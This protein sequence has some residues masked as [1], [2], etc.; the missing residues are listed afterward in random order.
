MADQTTV[1]KEKGKS[2]PMP[3]LL[4]ITFVAAIGVSVVLMTV[5]FKGMMP[6]GNRPA[7]AEA[8]EESET[9]F[10]SVIV[11]Y[12]LPTFR[13]NLSGGGYL[14]ATVVLELADNSVP[15]PEPKPVEGE[16]KPEAEAKKPEGGGHGG[17][18]GEAQAKPAETP[19]AK[20][21]A[22]SPFV[23]Y[24][25]DYRA[26]FQDIVLTI[27]RSQTK[28]DVL[29]EDGTQAVKNEIKDSINRELNP[30]MGLVKGVFFEEFVTD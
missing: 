23:K 26:K 10:E 15:P 28:E 19:A 25:D 17:G 18:G 30:Q 4:G 29:S 9:A 24:L 3:M 5:I 22:P 21:E 20:E 1:Q 11:H 6:K 7:E 27:L 16:K 14:K 12:P 8:Q 2:L 13:C